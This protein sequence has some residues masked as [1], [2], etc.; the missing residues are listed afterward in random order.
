MVEIQDRPGQQDYS[1]RKHPH[2]R[3][4]GR[5]VR[6]RRH[7]ALQLPSLVL[8][9][10]DGGQLWVKFV[11]DEGRVLQP[12]RL[13]EVFFDAEHFFDGYIA[14]PEHTVRCIQAAE[15]AGAD[16]II[17]CDTNGGMIPSRLQQIVREVFSLVKVPLGI[18]AHNDSDLAVA[19]SLAAVQEG[20]VQIQGTINGYG[21]RCGNAN[22]CSVI[23]S[24]QVKMNMP[25]VPKE[26]LRTLRECSRFVAELANQIPDR[27]RPYVGE[28]AFAHKGGIHVSAVTKNPRTYENIPPETVGNQRRFIVSDVSG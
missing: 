20:A 16:C 1:R 19:N 2:G 22:L 11:D 25:C 5:E 13:E 12:K 21:E 8:P 26:K 7:R 14:N 15:E 23:P 27:Q 28:N 9:V 10:G 24:L 6:G 3:R 4:K 17:L 18:H